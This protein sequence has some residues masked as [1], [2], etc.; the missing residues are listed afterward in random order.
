LSLSWTSFN[1]GASASVSF[2]QPNRSSIAINRI[3]SASPSQI[4][5]R[6]S[7]NGQVVLVNPPG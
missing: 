2:N 7:S 4:L 6:L 1:I 3:G 5:G